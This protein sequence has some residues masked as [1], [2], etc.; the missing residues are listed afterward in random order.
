MRQINRHS[1]FAAAMCCGASLLISAVG[2][3]SGVLNDDS[4]VQY[5]A[6][7]ASDATGIGAEPLSNGYVFQ[8]E[9]G[10][11][12]RGKSVDLLNLGIPGAEADEIED[13]EAQ[14]AS[15]LGGI[16]LVTVFVGGNDL[17]NGRDVQ[18][19]EN[20]LSGILEEI[21]SETGAIIVIANLPDLTQLP[22]F[23][24]ENSE[25]VT[26]QRVLDFNAAIARQA[27]AYGASLVDLFAEPV[28]RFLVSSDGFHPNNAGHQRIADEFL[29]VIE[30]QLFAP[31]GQ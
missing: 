8:I 28:D 29:A 21:R 4:D 10:I 24:G 14:L 31:S 25:K 27:A 13:S 7:G 11:E 16:D 17:V 15:E 3:G 12:A 6:I 22:E 23:A 9:R 19:F 18:S 2:C 30:P 20:D 5:V 26:L 1:T